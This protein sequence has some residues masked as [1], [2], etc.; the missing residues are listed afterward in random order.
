M[1]CLYAV[2]LTALSNVKTLRGKKNMRK[3]DRCN[4]NI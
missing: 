4:E 2:T 3:G 1:R